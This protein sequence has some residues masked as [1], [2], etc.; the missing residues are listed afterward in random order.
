MPRCSTTSTGEW[1]RKACSVW[2]SNSTLDPDFLEKVS[3]GFCVF[4]EES[5]PG[6]A[7][8]CHPPR[9]LPDGA[10]PGSQAYPGEGQAGC[11]A[12]T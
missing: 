4:G 5:A 6:L 12:E 2:T 10:L 7:Y 9:A 8:R 3:V 1:L 11:I